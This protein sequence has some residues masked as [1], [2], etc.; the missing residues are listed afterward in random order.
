MTPDTEKIDRI[1]AILFDLHHTITKTNRSPI[2]IHRMAAES[3]GFDLSKFDDDRLREVLDIVVE[4]LT[5]FQ[6]ENR[7]GIHWGK[8]AEDWLEANRVF[9][10]ALG[11]TD[12]SDEQLME[13]EKQWK[14]ILNTYW[15]SLVEGAKE[16]FEELKNRGYILGVCTRRFD[17]PEKLLREWGI[18][19]LLSTVHYSAVVGYAKPS[20][21]TLLK[22][23]EDIKINPRLCAYVGNLVNA[24]VE[25]SLRAEMLPVLTVWSDEKER[26]IAP[27]GIVVIDRITELLDIFP[28]PPS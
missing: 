13:M 15:E 17:D 5:K 25:A 14:K 19:H 4:F 28:G 8:Q 12:V 22:A 2:D 6:V 10:E 11:F 21:F 20:P 9:I 16:T 1:R 23:A 18:E 27:E 26:D 3:A 24:D 7:V